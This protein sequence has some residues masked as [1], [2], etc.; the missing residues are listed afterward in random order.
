MAAAGPGP[1]AAHTTLESD[2]ADDKDE[3]LQ[4][5]PQQPSNNPSAL[6]EQIVV[7]N[8]NEN[9][10]VSLPTESLASKSAEAAVQQNGKPITESGFKNKLSA[11]RALQKQI[12]S[13]SEVVTSVTTLNSPDLTSADQI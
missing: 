13:A 7:V 11:F 9:S 8:T 5:T 1:A 3:T 4:L 12:E 6:L 2:T 10:Q